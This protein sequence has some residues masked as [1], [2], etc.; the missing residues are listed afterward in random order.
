MLKIY[1]SFISSIRIIW[2]KFSKK[3][4][5]GVLGDLGSGAGKGGG[6]GGSIREAGGPFGKAGAAR[7]EEYFHKKQKELLS[8][9][10]DKLTEENA[11]RENEIKK[12]Q[13]AI[14]RNKRIAE[15]IEEEI[16]DNKSCS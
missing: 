6:G 1:H 13:S 15:E 9:L 8:E 2:R 10:K 4:D 7:E 12:H 11:L 3:Y 5:T 14:K 16:D